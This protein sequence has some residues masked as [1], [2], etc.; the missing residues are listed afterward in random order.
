MVQEQ[1]RQRKAYNEKSS[2][3][4]TASAAPAAAPPAEQQAPA[5]PAEVPA[6]SDPQALRIAE[7]EAEN[8][9]LR[10]QLAGLRASMES[11]KSLV[12]SDEHESSSDSDPTVASDGLR[13]I[14]LS[15]DTSALMPRTG[16]VSRKAYEKMQFECDDMHERLSAAIGE[17]SRLAATV[18]QR[19][20]E[21]KDRADEVSSLRMQLA[22]LAR[23]LT[24][25]SVPL[26][27]VGPG[28]S[29]S[30]IAL[31]SIGVARTS[32]LALG[33]RQPFQQERLSTAPAPHISEDT[34]QQ[35]VTIGRGLR[36]SV[37]QGMVDSLVHSD[38][39][40][41][42]TSMPVSAAP[43]GAPYMPPQPSAIAAAL[44]CS[45]GGS[46][47]DS[48]LTPRPPTTV[49]QSSSGR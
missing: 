45:T 43:S 36:K 22:D 6:E 16:F 42:T 25:G 31:R 10:M 23:M 48:S 44:M 41:P 15:D 47:K 8:E 7:L 11:L 30:S 4:D 20:L 40:R 9:Q 39:S 34:A 29:M 28:Q 12:R 24:S 32:M 33:V 1:E 19:D 2:D 38:Q 21:L 18:Q 35:P 27:A 17:A 37:A 46:S 3:G 26:A 49:D 13:E 5:A 14:S